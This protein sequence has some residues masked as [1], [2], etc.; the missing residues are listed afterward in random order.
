MQTLEEQAASQRNC[1]EQEPRAKPLVLGFGLKV[2]RGCVGMMRVVLG[3]FMQVFLAVRISASTL[4]LKFFAIKGR[5]GLLGSWDVGSGLAC[6]LSIVSRVQLSWCLWPWQ[7][8]LCK[9]LLT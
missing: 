5:Q 3:Q 9:R 8:Y 6:N 7:R 4:R 2:H 1:T